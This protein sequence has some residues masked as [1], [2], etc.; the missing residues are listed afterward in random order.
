MIISGFFRCSCGKI[1]CYGGL[2]IGSLCVCGRKLYP[3]S[4]ENRASVIAVKAAALA[5][6]QGLR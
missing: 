3:Q 6:R 2:N 5:V 1:H 4:I